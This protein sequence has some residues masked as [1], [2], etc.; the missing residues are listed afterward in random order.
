MKS[1]Q[2]LLLDVLLNGRLVPNR[3]GIDTLS[4][5]GRMFRH[6]LKKGFPLLT[7]KRVPPRSVA[8]ELIWMLRGETTLKF[9]HENN[10]K[11]WDANAGSTADDADLGPVYG[12]QLRRIVSSQW[13]E[14]RV[15]EHKPTYTTAYDRAIFIDK[16]PA[17]TALLG[18]EVETG[19]GPCTVI[20][21][22][23]DPGAHTKFLVKFHRSGAT[24]IVSYNDVQSGKIMDVWAP[25]VEG[26]GCYG[27]YDYNDPDVPTL[28][29]IWRDML[30]RCYD[31]KDT[32]YAAYGGAGV[33]VDMSWQIFANFLRDAKKLPNWLLKKEYPA[34]YSI[35]KDARHAANRYNAE[36]CMW[37]T[38]EEQALNTSTGTPFTA[39]SPDGREVLFRSFGEAVREHGLNQSA[40]HRCLNGK[41]HTHHGWS[42]FAYLSQPGKVLR[43]RIFDQLRQVIASLKHDP[44]SR[45]HLIT[46]WNPAE[47]DQMKLPPC[48]GIATQFNVSDGRL[49]CMMTQRS[50]DYFLGAPWNI[51]S[52]ALLTHILARRT[53]LEPGELVIAF[54][55]LHLYTNHLDQAREQLSRAPRELPTLKIVQDRK[56]PEDHMPDDFVFEGYNP[57]PAIK[58]DMAV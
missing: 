41:L 17:K 22:L 56:E 55:D 49:N 23:P 11:V 21:E 1:Y 7:T 42:N 52:Y 45:R 35:D 8:T 47:I 38:K 46:L 53:G 24:R 58:G 12:K 6:D 18:R 19:D 13:V 54:G 20:K 9:L 37:A 44:T 33:H 31:V 51:A 2:E 36:N 16:T 25:R 43:T 50:A 40:V 5:F 29:P 10:V 34:L 32:S 48:H 27:E 15:E 30:G 3:T 4:V 28:L 39:I 57:H 26:V 14:P